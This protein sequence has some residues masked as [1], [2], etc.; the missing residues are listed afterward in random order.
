MPDI[1]PFIALAAGLGAVVAGHGAWRRRDVNRW[2]SAKGLT[3]RSDN[4]RFDGVPS[5]TSRQAAIA[6]ADR[7]PPGTLLTIRHDPD[8]PEITQS[9]ESRLPI[10]RLG[11]A[12]FLAAMS[13]LALWLALP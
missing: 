3:Y 13:A 1:A 10:G 2:P 12:A 7:T 4:G 8:N 11:L 6:H 9:G 5:F